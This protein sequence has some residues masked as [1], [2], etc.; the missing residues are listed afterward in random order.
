MGIEESRTDIDKPV[1]RRR[2]SIKNGR[3]A[4]HGYIG[5]F[6]NCVRVYLIGTN[7]LPNSWVASLQA[8]TITHVEIFSTKKNALFFANLDSSMSSIYFG[9][10]RY[11][12][13]DHYKAAI[14]IYQRRMQNDKDAKE[15][16]MKYQAAFNAR[17]RR[18]LEE[19][20][21]SHRS[22]T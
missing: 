15:R 11:S 13:I 6:H 7:P 18:Q 16:T 4:V 3:I 12:F 9:R 2:T 1:I 8:R 14:K 19:Y 22:N 17:K 20:L 21:S 5:T 10:V